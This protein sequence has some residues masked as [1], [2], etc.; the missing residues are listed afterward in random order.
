MGRQIE[1][2]ATDHAQLLHGAPCLLRLRQLRAN[3]RPLLVRLP[4]RPGSGNLFNLDGRLIN[5]KAVCQEP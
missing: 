1:L 2:R 4:A 5:R 3:R